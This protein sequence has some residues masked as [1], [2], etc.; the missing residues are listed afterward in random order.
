MSKTK[1]STPYRVHLLDGGTA[2]VLARSA[3]GAASYAAQVA[4]LAVD[5]RVKPEWLDKDKAAEAI[6]HQ[7]VRV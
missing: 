5:P 6:N 1:P 3:K 2:V 7:E 4:G